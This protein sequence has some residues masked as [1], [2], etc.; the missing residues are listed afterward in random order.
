MS[1]DTYPVLADEDVPLPSITFDAS[2][3]LEDNFG[4]KPYPN[5][6]IPLDKDLSSIIP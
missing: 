5:D 2:D 1:S 6:L 3:L 4:Q